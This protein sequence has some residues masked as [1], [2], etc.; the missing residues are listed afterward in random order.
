MGIA[1]KREKKIWDRSL[2]MTTFRPKMRTAISEFF[3]FFGDIFNSESPNFVQMTPGIV[4][5]KN[6]A[7]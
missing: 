7:Q 5:S 1:A 4:P 3:R 2:K 6:S